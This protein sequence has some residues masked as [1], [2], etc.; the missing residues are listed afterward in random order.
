MKISAMHYSFR[1][2]LESGELDTAAMIRYLKQLDVS[3]VEL[4][5]PFVRDRDLDAIQ[6]ALSETG[7]EVVSYVTY[8]DFI[9]SDPMARQS[10]VTRVRKS[11]G[12]R[13]CLERHN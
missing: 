12:G 2:A 4:S 3:A 7:T 11:L 6:T 13:Q 9:T 8:C 10:Q 1:Q 5:E